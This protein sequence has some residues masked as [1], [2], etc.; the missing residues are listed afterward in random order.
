MF[1]KTMVWMFTAVYRSSG[2]SLSLRYSMALLFPQDAKTASTASWVEGEN[3]V[4]VQ[5]TLAAGE[6]LTIVSEGVNSSSSQGDGRG[7]L[8]SI[9]VTPVPEPMTVALLGLGGL[10]LRRRK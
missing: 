5:V 9:A 3:Y 1:P 7:F 4:K 10:F 2:I 8:N 6:Y